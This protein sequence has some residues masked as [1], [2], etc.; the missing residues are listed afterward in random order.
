[1]NGEWI[2]ILP[3]SFLYKNSFYVTCAQMDWGDVDKVNFA[4]LWYSHRQPWARAA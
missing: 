1:M 2:L 4:V 3:M